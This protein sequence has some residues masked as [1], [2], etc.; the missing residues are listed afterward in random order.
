MMTMT[1]PVQRAL[2]AFSVVAA[3]LI[4]ALGGCAGAA[5]CFRN[6]DCNSGYG[7]RHGK[8]QLL[9][10]PD[11]GDAGDAGAVTDGDAGSID[12]ASATD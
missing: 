8:C 1:K 6:S 9:S 7:C 11:A 3:A 10:P 4:A 2:I 5:V 12:D